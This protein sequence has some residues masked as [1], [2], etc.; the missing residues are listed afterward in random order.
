MK[1]PNKSIAIAM[2]FLSIPHFSHAQSYIGNMIDNYSGVNSILLNPA[3]VA[4]SKT[5]FEF[6]IISV[7]AFVGN[8][9]LGV[10]FQDLKNIGDGFSFDSD[11]AKSPTNSNNF[12]GNVDILGPG[13]M[14]RLNKKS[15]LGINTR[16][17]TFFNIHNIS[18]LIYENISD[19]FDSQSDFQV[20]MQNLAGTVHAW[21]EFGVTYGRVLFEDNSSRLKIG[22]T[23]KYLAGA[24]GLFT[25]SPR[26]GAGFNSAAG[27]LTT[28]GTL[29]YGYT[30]D[31]DSGEIEFSDMTGGFGADFGIVY[32][33][34]SKS[35]IP[36]DS[37]YSNKPYKLRFGVSIL[38]IGAIN[39]TDVTEFNYG[40]NSSINVAEFDEKD[41]EEVLN[42]NFQGTEI[43]GNKSLGLPSSIQA[44]A[45][46]NVSKKFFL[47]LHGA[48]SLRSP[49]TFNVNNIVN[50]ISVTPRFESKFLSVYSP[51]SLR[52]F[53]SGIM[54]G[55]GFRAGP[56][57]I[58]SGSVL[59][60]LLS[61]SSKSTDVFIG[62]KVPVHKN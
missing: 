40:M 10:N 14:F 11:V 52:Q 32:E 18:G 27:I 50:T 37:A 59:S 42:D 60:N 17:R 21:G 16:V 35:N 29:D 5:K 62:F 8:D 47:S 22:T 7:S 24:G 31:F 43:L 12:F 56:F 26:L 61:S 46:Y 3:N 53:Q 49:S 55:I 36:I 51:L 58:G 48:Y 6:N 9:Y 44:F 33:L 57:M 25:S 41:L 23:I 15:S 45:D 30:S 20:D 4:G 39:Y 1:H 28:A 2:M 19:G 38:D 54:W 34:R 13:V